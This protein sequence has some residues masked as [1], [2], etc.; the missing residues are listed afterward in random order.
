MKREPVVAGMFYP[1]DPTVLQTQLGQYILD[2]QPKEKAIGIVSPHA[3]YMYSG[4]CA[5]KV[6]GKIV[7][8]GRVIIIGVN[9]SG[10]GENFAVD[11]S[12]SWYTPLGEVKLDQAFCQNLSENSRHFVIDSIAGQREHSLEVQVPFV[13]FLNPEARIV[14][15]TISSSDISDLTESGHE[16]AA[17]I[18]N[19]SDT[20]LV[21]S[22]DMSHYISAEKA[23]KL[24]RMAIDKILALDP[25]GLL[26]VVKANEISMCGVAPTVIML[27]AALALGAEKAE[28]VEY[29]N[30]GEVS[31][32]FRQVVGYSSL[33][34]S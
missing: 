16:L 8:P 13:K 33:L 19:P 26:E 22:T 27:T 23:R 3:G 5:G 4:A 2:Q 11:G 28:L 20:L 24:D 15:L 34:V 18:D 17:V 31:G 10:W 21:A 32:D 12:E 9:H 25:P 30:S 1:S 6:F 7:I 14:P 29:T